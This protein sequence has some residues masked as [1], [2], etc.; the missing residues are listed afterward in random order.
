MS[1]ECILGVVTKKSM[2]YMKKNAEE[3][4]KQ[5]AK[6]AVAVPDVALKAHKYV[7]SAR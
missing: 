6:T 5:L 4:A 3:K 1:T 2:E 7:S